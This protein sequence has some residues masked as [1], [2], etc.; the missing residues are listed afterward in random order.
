MPS[1]KKKGNKSPKSPQNVRKHY[2][3]LHDKTINKTKKRNQKSTLP[4]TNENFCW[5]FFGFFRKKKI[6][7]YK[8][9]NEK[10][11]KESTKKKRKK[12]EK[13]KWERQNVNKTK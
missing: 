8:K 12:K 9:L 13:I 6:K 7:I 2:R 1:K 10:T 4:P 3:L 11:K 5:S